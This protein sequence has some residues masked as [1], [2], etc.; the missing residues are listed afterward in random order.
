MTQFVLAAEAREILNG[1]SKVVDIAGRA[2]AIFNVDGTFVAIDNACPHMQGPL[3][4]GAVIDG[5]VRCPWHGWMFD[6]VSGECALV[7]HAKLTH[8]PIRLEGGDIY[9]GVDAAE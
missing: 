5:H 9:V 8:L 7:P 3:G 6:I 4:D 2:V 1:A